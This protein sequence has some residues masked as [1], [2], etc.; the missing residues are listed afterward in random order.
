MAY[1]FLEHMI[2]SMDECLDGEPLRAWVEQ[3]LEVETVDGRKTWVTR[4][5]AKKNML[6]W[7]DEHLSLIIDTKDSLGTEL[8]YRLWCEAKDNADRLIARVYDVA[9]DLDDDEE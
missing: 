6:D 4:H 9:P 1:A 2:C 7:I 8:Q 5:D 3:F